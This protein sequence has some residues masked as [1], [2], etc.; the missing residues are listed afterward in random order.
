MLQFMGSQRVR[1]DLE[2]KHQQMAD[3][4]TYFDVLILQIFWRSFCDKGGRRDKRQDK[5]WKN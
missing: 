1:Q 4:C 2:T 5:S 3:C